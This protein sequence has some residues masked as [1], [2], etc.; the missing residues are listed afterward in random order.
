M[1]ASPDTYVPERGESTDPAKRVCAGCSVR[2]QCLEYAMTN[3]KEKQ[4]VW[5]GLSWRERRQL[6]SFTVGDPLPE[7]V[8]IVDR[9]APEHPDSMPEVKNHGTVGGFSAHY[10]RGEDP[11]EA[12]D[13]AKKEYDA[14]RAKVRNAR[15]REAAARRRE[16]VH[17]S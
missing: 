15:K 2:S 9:P 7:V 12:C 4:G 1:G 16:E 6:G 11:C 8:L 10:R 3:P 5:G 17:A 14:G 13:L